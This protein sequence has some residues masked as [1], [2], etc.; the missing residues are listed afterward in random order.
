MRKLHLLLLIGPD[1]IARA[2]IP[3]IAIPVPKCL[4]R[5]TIFSRPRR[6]RILRIERAIIS[7]PLV[8]M[9]LFDERWAGEFGGVEEGA[10]IG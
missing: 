4:A 10:H 6:A 1:S 8:A 2:L 7:Q 3:L 9:F 5:A